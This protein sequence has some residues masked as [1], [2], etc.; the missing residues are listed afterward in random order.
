MVSSRKQSKP[1]QSTKTLLDGSFQHTGMCWMPREKWANP[2]SW[3]LLRFPTGF[4]ILA[5]LQAH[6]PRLH[7]LCHAQHRRLIEMLTHHLHSDRQSI[8]RRPARH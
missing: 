1:S 4:G 3:Y 6:L 2:V 8:L 5:H 7:R